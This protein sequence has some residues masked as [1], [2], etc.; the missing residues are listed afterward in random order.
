MSFFGNIDPLEFLAEKF[1]WTIVP[2]YQTSKKRSL[3]IWDTALL[4]PCLP[5][6]LHPESKGKLCLA[7]NVAMR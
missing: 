5:W 4:P 2:L 3:L 1:L 7:Q 6:G